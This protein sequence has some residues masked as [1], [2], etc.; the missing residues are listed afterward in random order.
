MHSFLPFAAEAAPAGGAALD[1]VAGVTLAV[2]VFTALL[3]LLGLG[4]RAGRVQVLERVSSTLGR[5]SGLPGWAALPLAI[6]GLALLIAAIGLYWDVSLH[7]DQGRDEGP[8]ANPSHYFI[9]VGLYGIFAAGWL[10]MVLPR[11]GGA[12]RAPG[13][14]RI[15]LR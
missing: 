12:M 1:Q 3:M 5:F 14:A 13:R 11:G 8:L 7:I 2:T 15:P 10:A 4:H 6:S 9:L